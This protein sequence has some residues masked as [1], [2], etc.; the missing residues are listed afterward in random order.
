M[1][2]VR[3]VHGSTLLNSSSS[4]LQRHTLFI[5]RRYKARH[6]L[7]LCSRPV[8]MGSVCRAYVRRAIFNTTGS[9]NR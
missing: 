6:T 9:F 7:Y 3:A 8:N 1:V 4:A 5:E 2:I